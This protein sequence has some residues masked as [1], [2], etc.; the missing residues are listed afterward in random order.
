MRHR[1]LALRGEGGGGR[2]I[3]DTGATGRQSRVM[4]EDVL[5]RGQPE[6]Q[7]GLNLTLDGALRKHA[8]VAQL[9]H[10]RRLQPCH[11]LLVGRHQL[12]R[13]AR[14]LFAL[15]LLDLPC[16]HRQ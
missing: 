9:A 3:P 14:A 6:L 11:L 13:G 12:A 5:Y 2:A 16:P 15:R 10:E 4:R 8:E 7:K 1:N